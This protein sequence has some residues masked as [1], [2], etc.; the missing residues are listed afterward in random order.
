MFLARR[1]PI[2]KCQCPE[3]SFLPHPERQ[4]KAQQAGRSTRTQ[5]GRSTR[6]PGPAAD[7]P[8]AQ[9]PGWSCLPP[10]SKSGRRGDSR[11]V[12]NDMV[13]MPQELRSFKLVYSSSERNEQRRSKL[14]AINWPQIEASESLV[15]GVPMKRPLGQWADRSRRLK[16][17]LRH[18]LAHPRAHLGACVQI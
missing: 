8:Q 15:E 17:G 4:S 12:P 10:L 11:P 5:A 9:Q 14:V 6:T 3:P 2:L 16:R 1:I 7:R 13:H 18:A